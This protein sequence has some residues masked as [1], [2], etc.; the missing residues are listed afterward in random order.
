MKSMRRSIGYKKSTD[1]TEEVLGRFDEPEGLIDRPRSSS[2]SCSAV[3]VTPIYL[4]HRV[5]LIAREW[6]S[7]TFASFDDSATA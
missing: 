5:C 6:P 1:P 7:D 3:Y 2:C 4:K